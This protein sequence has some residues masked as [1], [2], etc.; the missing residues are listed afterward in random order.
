MA[1]SYLDCYVTIDNT[2]FFYCCDIV[3]TSRAH[4]VRDGFKLLSVQGCL[5]SLCFTIL[6]NV[7]S[8]GIQSSGAHARHKCE[9]HFYPPTFHTLM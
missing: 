8:T 2:F 4:G 6:N 1:L 7:T 3:I 5:T 9:S